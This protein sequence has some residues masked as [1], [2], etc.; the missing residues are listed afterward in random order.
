[1]CIRDSAKEKGITISG[2]GYYPNPMDPDVEKAVFYREHIKTLIKAAAKLGLQN[3]NTFIGRDPSKN[4]TEN[5]K[6][7]GEVWPEIVK[8]AD[9]LLY[10]SRCV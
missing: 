7:F 4:V 10:T 1:M 8:V 2:L 9:C 6:L 3:V 5:L